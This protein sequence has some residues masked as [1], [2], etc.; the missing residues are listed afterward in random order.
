MEKK[1]TITVDVDGN[2]ISREY[3]DDLGFMD[4]TVW[5]VRV[6]DMLDTLEKSNEK[7]F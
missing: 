6:M 3:K 2:A 4:G 5:A 1:I 7:E